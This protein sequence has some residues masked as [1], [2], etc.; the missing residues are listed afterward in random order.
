MRLENVEFKNRFETNILLEYILRFGV[1]KNS[2]LI[3]DSQG[4]AN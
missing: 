3:I 2:I 4:S 1:L